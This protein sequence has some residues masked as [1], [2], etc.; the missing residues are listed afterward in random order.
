MPYL[1]PSD[2]LAPAHRQGATDYTRWIWQDPLRAS[3]RVGAALLAAATSILA[4]P[5]VQAT[6]A[7]HIGAL[8][9]EL[10]PAYAPVATAMLSAGFAA[11]SKAS[12]SR[13]KRPT[14]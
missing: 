9:G 7:A 8:A 6:L 14:R 5:E 1:H 11:W 4:M 12:D 13:P 3:K 2:P 10:D